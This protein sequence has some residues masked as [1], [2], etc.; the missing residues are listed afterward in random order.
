MPRAHLS[1][2]SD[3]G[4]ALYQ[5]RSLSQQ[6]SPRNRHVPQSRGLEEKEQEDIN[7]ANPGSQEIQSRWRGRERER[8][9]DESKKMW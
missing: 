5:P 1:L 9:V 3:T 7:S 6:A 8:N 4:Q 2:L